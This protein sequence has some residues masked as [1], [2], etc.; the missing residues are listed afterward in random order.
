MLRSSLALLPLSASK[1]K[2]DVFNSKPAHLELLRSSAHPTALDQ[3]AHGNPGCRRLAPKLHSSGGVC[4]EVLIAGPAATLGLAFVLP[5]SV[6]SPA[7]F[8]VSK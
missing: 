3:S 2:P 4:W 8:Y 1:S 5:C 7:S 6:N